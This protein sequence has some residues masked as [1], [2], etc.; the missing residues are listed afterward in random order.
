LTDAQS[1]V[2]PVAQI[3]NLPYRRIAFGQARQ[4]RTPASCSRLAHFKSAIRPSATLRY[5]AAA[6]PA[7]R[8]RHR[9]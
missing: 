7:F 5:E 3:F 9:K 6:D 4:V 2:K 8:R 1:E